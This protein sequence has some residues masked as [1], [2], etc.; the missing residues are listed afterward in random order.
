[1]LRYTFMRLWEQNAPISTSTLFTGDNTS[2][3]I[4]KINKSMTNLDGG[5]LVEPVAN[6]NPG[7]LVLCQLPFTTDVSDITLDTL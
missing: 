2:S 7:N 6:S 1:M 4:D 3:Y 5:A